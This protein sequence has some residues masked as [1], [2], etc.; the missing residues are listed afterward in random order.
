MLV[1]A[2]DNIRDI[3]NADTFREMADACAEAYGL[4]VD[5]GDIQGMLRAADAFDLLD[6]EF[7][8]WAYVSAILEGLLQDDEG[9]C[10]E[11]YVSSIAALE[12]MFGEKCRVASTAEALAYARAKMVFAAPNTQGYLDRDVLCEDIENFRSG[13]IDWDDIERMIC[14]AETMWRNLIVY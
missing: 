2:D 7:I 8:Y 10:D 9:Y 12:G 6:D 1:Y 5:E 11:D 3:V 4:P 14:L 13:I